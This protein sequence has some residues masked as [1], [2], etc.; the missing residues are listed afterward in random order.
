[1][2]T[3]VA[4]AAP[5][6]I[7]AIDTHWIWQDGQAL[8]RAPYPIV[9]GHLTVPDAPGLGVELDEAAVDA[10]HQLYLREG[11]GGRDDAIAMQYLVPGWTFDAKRPALQ[12][13]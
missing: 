13:V 1:M 7:T 2:F 8:T 4:A 12:R 5:G 10:A 3:H 9:D 11:L 6:N